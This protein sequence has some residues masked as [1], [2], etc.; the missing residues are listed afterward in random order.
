[1]IPKPLP[2]V[3]AAGLCVLGLALGGCGGSSLI[4]SKSSATTGSAPGAAANGAASVGGSGSAT[5]S[6]S[7]SSG[8]SAAGGS[9]GSGSSGSG[10][11]GSGSAGSGSAGSS[12]SGSRSPSGSRSRSGSGSR[13][14]SRSRSGTRGQFGSG[15]SHS[16][17]H[18]S[19]AG[20]SSSS[21][22]S[23]FVVAADGIC[24]SYRQ[25]VAPLSSAS[26]FAAT[27]QVAPTLIGDAR[28]AVTKLQALSAPP[29]AAANFQQFTSM[30]TSAIDQFQ[31]AQTRSMSTTESVGVATE[32]QDMAAYESAIKDAQTAAAAAQ[33]LGFQV[34]GSAGSDWL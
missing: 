19:P 1:M 31:A 14:G 16:R 32:Q 30:T 23:P 6:T 20:A 8:G 33:T 15:S 21:P 25:Q 26:G 10:S 17:S 7:S 2:P 24:R 12:S 22:P 29:A 9:S 4:Q 34:C 5:A 13:S 28:A 27:E 11:S 18:R 3:A